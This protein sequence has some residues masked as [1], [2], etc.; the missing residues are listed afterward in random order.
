MKTCQ[1]LIVDDEPIIIKVLSFVFKK[2]GCTV[3]TANDGEEG[4]RKIKELKPK[5]VLLDVMMPKK[6]GLDLCSEVKSDP[7]FKDTYIILLTAKGQ[8]DD[9]GVGYSEGAD[10][11][12]TK[13]FNLLDVVKKIK[14][15]LT[16]L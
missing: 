5:I 1:I 3:E 10:D 9:V 4:M 12:I 6:S 8:D 13:P 7:K 15:L 2:E 11:Y 16:R 14:E